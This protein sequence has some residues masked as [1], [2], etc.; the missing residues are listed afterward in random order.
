MNWS[1]R[2]ASNLRPRD[3][4]SRA[5]PGCA[6]DRNAPRTPGAGRAHIARRQ[7][8]PLNPSHTGERPHDHLSPRR[9]VAPGDAL[10][11]AHAAQRRGHGLR[12]RQPPQDR[13]RSTRRCRGSDP[14]TAEESDHADL[15]GGTA[16]WERPSTGWMVAEQGTARHEPQPSQ[17][18]FLPCRFKQPRNRLNR[19]LFYP[20]SYARNR[21]GCPMAP[22]KKSR[23]WM[24]AQVNVHRSRRPRLHCG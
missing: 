19:T 23:R 20:R 16:H 13:D 24:R 18:I 9:E 21:C 4:K 11:W 17:E 3:P 12:K 10:P 14:G 5:L 2:Q 7:K 8:R 1:T 15:T 22:R 6:T